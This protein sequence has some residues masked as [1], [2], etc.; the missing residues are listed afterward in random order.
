MSGHWTRCTVDVIYDPADIAELTIEYAD[1]APWKARRLVIGERTGP[2][3]K[4]PGRLS[5]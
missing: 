3:P 4:L 2:R 5:P 1:H